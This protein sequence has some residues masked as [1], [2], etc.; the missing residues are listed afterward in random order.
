MRDVFNCVKSRGKTAANADVMR[1]SHVA[2]HAAA[3]AWKLGRKL[4]IDPV[5]EE[6]ID[7]EEANRM[8][9]RSARAPWAI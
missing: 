8:R 2:C 4:R 6:F 7:D 9:S 5:N 3:L 1:K